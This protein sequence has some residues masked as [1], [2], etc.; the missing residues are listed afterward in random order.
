MRGRITEAAVT[1]LLDKSPMLMNQ[2]KKML[3]GPGA[4]VQWLNELVALA[5]DTHGSSQMSKT[6][7]PGNTKLSA[8]DTNVVHR[9]ICE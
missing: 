3:R 8:L 7:V 2:K 4:I 6:L 5:E 1:V 9:H